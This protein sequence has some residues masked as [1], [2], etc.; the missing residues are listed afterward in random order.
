MVQ[1]HLLGDCGEDEPSIDCNAVAVADSD[2]FTVV[3]LVASGKGPS[4]GVYHA[5][6]CL[7]PGCGKPVQI[8]A[9]AEAGIEI[10]LKTSTRL[11][12]TDPDA[13]R[14]YSTKYGYR[15]V[16]FID[17]GSNGA[18]KWRNRPAPCEADNAKVCCFADRPAVDGSLP[19]A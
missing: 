15:L 14:M 5:D 19:A 16:P 12:R 11:R 4:G 17:T 1:P 18:A 13:S 6:A 9:L 8:R 10:D 7:T 3:E 2:E